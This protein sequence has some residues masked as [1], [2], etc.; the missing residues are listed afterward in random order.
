MHSERFLVAIVE[1]IVC[2]FFAARSRTKGRIHFATSYGSVFAS[3][4]T[5]RSC[6]VQY[7]TQRPL[8]PN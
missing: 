1:A 3:K 2:I 5:S 6:T 4:A 7:K 8:A